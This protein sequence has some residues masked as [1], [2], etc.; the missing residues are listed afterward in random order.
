MDSKWDVF[1]SYSRKDEAIVFEICQLLRENT[2]SY[3]IDKQKI[4]SGSFFMGDIVDAIKHSKITLFVS[5]ENSNRSLYTAKEIAYAFNEGKYIIPYKI[6]KSSFNKNLEL[7]LCDL[8]CVEAIPFDSQKAKK[9]IQDI[10]ALLYGE[11]QNE[12]EDIPIRNYV[13]VLTWDEP[14]NRILRYLN[15]LFKDKS[16]K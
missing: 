13:D 10:K 5:S 16:I 1:I 11:R 14:H 3:W 6:D 12:V 2:I 15:K 8:N 7:V 4:H 9:L